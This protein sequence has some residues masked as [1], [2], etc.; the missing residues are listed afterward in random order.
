[1]A[2]SRRPPSSI[3]DFSSAIR[4]CS[5]SGLGDISCGRDGSDRGSTR[6]R[7]KRR[8]TVN[9]KEH[10]LAERFLRVAPAVERL[11]DLLGHL[12]LKGKEGIVRRDRLAMLANCLCLAFTTAMN[13]FLLLKASY[14]RR[15]GCKSCIHSAICGV[16]CLDPG[17][18]EFSVSRKIDFGHAFGGLERRSSSTD[19]RHGPDVV[20]RP[21]LAAHYPLADGEVGVRG[22]GPLCFERRFI[23][24]G[25]QHVDQIDI[26]GEFRVFLLGDAAGNENAENGRRSRNRVDDGLSVCPD[27]VDVA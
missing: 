20:E 6:R 21:R 16:P 1:M 23:E 14:C 3:R 25:R 9:A 13:G 27:L 22:L 18:D 4:A 5:I 11:N 24:T 19:C 8:R 10:C 17:L 12:L 15:I 26:A 7:L 2:A